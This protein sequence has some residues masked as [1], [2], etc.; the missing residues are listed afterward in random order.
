MAD[1]QR[2]NEDLADTTLNDDIRII[3]SAFAA[4]VIAEVESIMAEY[5]DRYVLQ[6]RTIMKIGQLLA[7]GAGSMPSDIERIWKKQLRNMMLP[8]SSFR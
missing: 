6:W 5:P 3:N 4:D 1:H 2:E 8:K 7:P